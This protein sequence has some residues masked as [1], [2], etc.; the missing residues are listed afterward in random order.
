MKPWRKVIKSTWGS[1]GVHMGERNWR[2]GTGRYWFLILACQHKAVRPF[3]YF[4]CTGFTRFN[5]EDA[6]PAPKRVR[7]SECK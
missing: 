2:S 3:R 6:L 4:Q 7:C 5:F 1:R